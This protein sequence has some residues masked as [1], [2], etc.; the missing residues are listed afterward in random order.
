[1]AAVPD[2]PAFLKSLFAAA[3]DATS[4]AR[5]LPVHLPAPPRGRTIVIGAG[6][7]AAAMA[8]T[9]EAHWQGPLGGLVITRYGHGAACR[10]IEVVEAGHPVPDTAGLDAATRMLAMV[11]GLCPEDLVLCLLS[12][13]GSALL[14]LPP[15]TVPLDDKR[16]V[17]KALLRCGATISEI[18]TVRKHLSRIKGGQLALACAPAPVHTLIISD[19]PGD[20]PS[21]VA[22]GPT[23]ADPTNAADARA[24][25]EK[26]GL[27]APESVT[28]HLS[29]NAAET[30]SPGDPRLTG[31]QTTVIAT[32]QTALD[33]AAALCRKHGITPVILGNSIEGESRDVALVLAGIA[34][35]VARH[36]QPAS[37]PCVLLSGGETTVTVRSE[38]ARGGR[39]AEFQLALAVA[40]D[41]DP[42]IHAL[43]CDTDGIDGTEDNAGAIIAPETLQHART[44]GLDAKA[45]L[46]ANA[47]YDFFDRLGALIKTGPTRTNVNDFR[48]ILVNT[49]GKTG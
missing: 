47:S 45:M 49:R 36:G 15:P 7:A 29:S 23:V 4:A 39:N 3:I 30:S 35:Q 21:I 37:G 17:T 34:R 42:D 28:A 14:T 43:A 10:S 24:V 1:M 16:A 41:G 9:A 38:A 20:D 19:V 25:I 5:C 32:A 48:A 40:L 8:A 31:N 11:Q 26:Y 18:N 6:K 46:A 27:E 22:S 12:G 13:G 33:A 44:Q 2:P